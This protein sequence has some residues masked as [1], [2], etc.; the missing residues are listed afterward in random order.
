MQRLLLCAVVLASG[1]AAEVGHP[2]EKVIGLLK[3]M[4]EEAK[5]IFQKEEINYAKFTTWCKGGDRV[6]KKAIAAQEEKITELEGIVEAK[7]AEIKELEEQIEE[8]EAAQKASDEA[9]D[10]GAK[11]Y[12]EAD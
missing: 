7:K 11:L 10:E 2:I 3:D 12:E 9:R 4:G 8:N 6:L 1:Y 5:G